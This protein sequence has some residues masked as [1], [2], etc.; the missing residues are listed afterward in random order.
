[1]RP[2]AQLVPKNDHGPVS[3]VTKP[4]F[5]GSCANAAV[6]HNRSGAPKASKADPF[7]IISP[8]EFLWF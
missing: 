6:A 4:I 5:T 1:L 7:F 8:P 2:A 3:S